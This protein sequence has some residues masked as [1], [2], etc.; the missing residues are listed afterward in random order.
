MLA[1][2]CTTSYTFRDAKSPTL[3]LPR[4]YCV[5]CLALQAISL[6]QVRTRNKI[7]TIAKYLLVSLDDASTHTQV[8]RLLEMR[9][10][11][12]VLFVDLLLLRGA[13][14][15]LLRVFFLLFGFLLLFCLAARLGLLF[16]T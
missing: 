10:E 16:A 9:A 14:L 6:T 4:H 5:F 7:N 1:E 11:Q 8:D 12:R 13:G 2:E 15:L 3:P